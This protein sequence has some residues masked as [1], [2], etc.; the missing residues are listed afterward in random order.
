MLLFFCFFP[1]K[2]EITLEWLVDIPLDQITMI[3]RHGMTPFN[4]WT[5]SRPSFWSQR[6]G[7]LTTMV[8][9]RSNLCSK[10]QQSWVENS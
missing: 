7:S 4:P 9:L 3:A 2:F 6:I 8:V 5:T 1:E 10:L